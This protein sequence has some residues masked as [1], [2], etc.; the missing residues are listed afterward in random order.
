M[1]RRHARNCIHGAPKQRGVL[2]QQHMRLAPDDRAPLHR[3]A[4]HARRPHPQRIHHAA[5]SINGSCNLPHAQPTLQ[6]PTKPLQIMHLVPIHRT[7]MR[8]IQLRQQTAQINHK[9]FSAAGILARR[10]QMMLFQRLPDLELPWHRPKW[11][12]QIVLNHAAHG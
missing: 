7:H 2:T 11:C 12:N 9:L 3:R 4:G 6:L 8:I 5:R 10:V 1:L